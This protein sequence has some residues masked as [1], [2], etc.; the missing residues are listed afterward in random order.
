MSVTRYV[1]RNEQRESHDPYRTEPNLTG[2]TASLVAEFPIMALGYVRR[3][4]A[5][6]MMPLRARWS[7]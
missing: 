4:P 1:T 6:E 7:A 3:E 5:D 2:P